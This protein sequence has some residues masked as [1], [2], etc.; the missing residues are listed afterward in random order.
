MIE[1]LYINKMDRKHHN[2]KYANAH[3]K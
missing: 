3:H 2:F 1:N